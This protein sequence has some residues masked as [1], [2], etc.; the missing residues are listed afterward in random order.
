LLVVIAIIAILI[1]LLLPAV[2]KVREAA[3]RMRCSNNLK[4]LGV[5]LHAHHDALGFYPRA[6]STTNGLGWTVMILPY[7]EQQ[8]LYSQISQAAGSYSSTTTNNKNTPFGLTKL[9]GFLCSSSRVDRM[10]MGALDNINPP[11]QVPANTGE[12][13]YTTHYYA[14]TGPVGTNPA[15]G[16]AYQVVTGNTHEGVRLSAQGVFARDVDIKITDITDGT[17]NTLAVGELSWVNPTS[18]SRF[19]SWLRGCEPVEVCA[20]ARNVTTAINAGLRVN[21]IVPYNN[22]PM[23]SMHSGGANFL[24]ADGS[25]SF[26]RE[27]IAIN[28][29]LSLASRNGGETVS[30]Y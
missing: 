6:G 2:Q 11:D 25:V 14:I 16:Q 24:F 19:R 30:G 4:Q 21:S 12:P 22:M 20:G 28:T 17:S 7:L 26:L 18:G 27:S 10:A 3:A 9:G 1:G 8:P 15:N 5:A 13:P 23:G 29:Y